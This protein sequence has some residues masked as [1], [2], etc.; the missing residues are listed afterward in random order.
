MSGDSRVKIRPQTVFGVN[1]LPGFKPLNRFSN[2]HNFARDVQ[3]GYSRH[4]EEGNSG[5]AAAEFP[6]HRVDGRRANLDEKL[7]VID[8]RLGNIGDFQ[9]LRR[10]VSMVESGFHFISTAAAQSPWSIFDTISRYAFSLWLTTLALY[11]C[12]LRRI[13][14]APKGLPS[15]SVQPRGT[16]LLA[17]RKDIFLFR[18][19][20]VS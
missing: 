4:P 19:G 9:N 16:I 14:P 18:K 20:V 15:P 10:S 11:Q 7:M 8:H 12:S 1:R 5:F 6:I 17:I 3:S 13:E 2:L